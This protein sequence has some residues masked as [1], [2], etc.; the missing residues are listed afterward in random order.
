MT[1]SGD[2]W[3]RRK[4]AVAEE[5]RTRRQAAEAGHEDAARHALAEKPDEQVLAELDL[6]DPDTLGRGDDFSAFMARA[7]PERLRRRALR[8][9]WLSDPV[10][11][12]LDDLLEYG[13][14]YTD[15]ATVVEG[16]QTVY[17]VGEGMIRKIAAAD[18]SDAPDPAP[19]ALPDP[20]SESDTGSGS[21]ATETPA[22]ASSIADARAAARHAAPDMDGERVL[23]APPP[24]RHMSFRFADA[25][26]GAG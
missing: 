22:D 9:L 21:A 2:F 11:A 7:V 6:P 24:K 20:D 19:D 26:A 17:R 3:S 1:G 5:E 12:N 23:P 16:L 14:D 25:G 15:A 10:L 4:E 18:D 8:R 13:E